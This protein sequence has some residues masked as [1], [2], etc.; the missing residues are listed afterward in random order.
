M[1]ATA[2]DP[3]RLIH[4]LMASDSLR[5][6]PVVQDD[7]YVGV[8]DWQTIRHLSGRDLDLPVARYANQDVPTLTEHTTIAEAMEAF[9]T[10]DVVAHGL[11]PVLDARGQLKGQIEREEFQGLMEDGSGGITVRKNPTAHLLTGANAPR[12]GAKVISSDGKKLGTFQGHAEDRGRPR[13]IVVR[14]GL[15][16]NKRKRH[17]PLVAI[18]HQTPDEIRLNIE[19]AIWA[20]FT[21]RP[22][23][24]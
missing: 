10:L 14:H 6:V 4:R 16:W 1:T 20:T 22:R 21:D 19:R 8:I 12:I 9:R 23:F 11:L 17:V 18:D 7:R 2:M 15:L 3:V 5:S 24:E 13:W